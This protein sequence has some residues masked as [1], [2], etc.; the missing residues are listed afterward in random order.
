MSQFSL[1]AGFFLRERE[2]IFFTY[3]GPKN[4]KSAPFFILFFFSSFCSLMS[5]NVVQNL[6][7]SYPV[8]TAT[9][10]TSGVSIDQSQQKRKH[11]TVCWAGFRYN[12]RFR[13]KTSTA[14]KSINSLVWISDTKH[15]RGYQ[16]A[17]RKMDKGGNS[18]VFEI[19][20][21]NFQHMLDSWFV[22][23]IWYPLFQELLVRIM[24]Q[25]INT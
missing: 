23:P 3:S 13:L 11:A 18:P 10:S 9:C 2:K 25:T 6:D 14:S 19:D 12:S 4:T 24:K 1:V 21:W 5:N 16:I 22:F 17:N 20:S 7:K 8:H 15:K